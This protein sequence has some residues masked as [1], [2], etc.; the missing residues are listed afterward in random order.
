MASNV[1]LPAA[2]DSQHT[3]RVAAEISSSRNRPSNVKQGPIAKPAVKRT[4]TFTGCWTCRSRGVKCD[5]GKP[6]CSRCTRAKLECQGYGL[7]LIWE[8]NKGKEPEKEIR[9]RIFLGPGQNIKPTLSKKEVNLNLQKVDLV[10]ETDSETLVFGPFSVFQSSVEVSAAHVL[11]PQDL[12]AGSGD[13]GL[14][15]HG[16][17]A[18]SSVD[19]ESEGCEMNVENIDVGDIDADEIEV[20]EI[21]VDEEVENPVRELV[22]IPDPNLIV[23]RR[24][25]ITPPRS[26]E[27]HSFSNP[28]SCWGSKEER[29]LMD[30]WLKSTSSKLVVNRSSNN[31]FR[32]VYLP[33]ALAS[34]Q[35]YGNSSGHSSLY[36]AICAAAAFHRAHVSNFRDA[37]I[38]TGIKH[39]QRSIRHLRHGLLATDEAEREATLAAIITMSSIDVIRGQTSNWKVHIRGGRDWLDSHR[40]STWNQSRSASIL[41][42]IFLCVEA[43]GSYGGLPMLNSNAIEGFHDGSYCLDS[44]FGITQ[45]VLKA[46]NSINRILRESNTPPTT[47]ELDSLELDI[48]MSDPSD[49]KFQDLDTSCA[50]ATRHQACA[51]H[52]ASLIY[53]KRTLKKVPPIGVQ[54]LVQQG[55]YHLEEFD[56]SK[57][58]EVTGFLWPAF[59][60]ACEAEGEFLRSR[61]ASWFERGERHGMRNISDA[62]RIVKEIWRRRDRCPDD[63]FIRGN[64]IMINME[65]DVLLT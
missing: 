39:H 55:I 45:P 7:R 65:F 22:A 54:N 37:E 46:I 30:Y 59:V 48:L 16:S 61:I 6:V 34:S 1:R 27:L 60:I 51:F 42:Q 32:T 28:F 8:W 40:L 18:S 9:R 14:A 25:A 58:L 56:R 29:Q 63:Q 17:L 23:V 50:E 19:L 43:I 2:V 3:V 13:V 21:N 33:L 57:D 5:E 20:E 4:K 10:T 47:D 11:R 26:P 62:G 44:V 38:A 53:F 36:H 12:G 31:P 52:Q 49:R 24:R 35:Q 15:R 41:Y 64:A